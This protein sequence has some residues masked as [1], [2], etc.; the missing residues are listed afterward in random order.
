[1]GQID[2][3]CSPGVKVPIALGGGLDRDGKGDELHSRPAAVSG[4]VRYSTAKKKKKAQGKGGLEGV[5][6]ESVFCAGPLRV[7]RALSKGEKKKSNG[8]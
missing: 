5:W 8:E 2:Q 3:R 4:V 6:P 1:V 7:L